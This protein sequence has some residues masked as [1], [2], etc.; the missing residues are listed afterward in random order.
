MRQDCGY[1]NDVVYEY[2]HANQ[3]VKNDCIYAHV[4]SKQST[5]PMNHVY[6]EHCILFSTTN[7]CDCACNELLTKKL[8]I[9]NQNESAERSL[10][11]K[12]DA[13]SVKNA[14]L[15]ITCKSPSKEGEDVFNCCVEKSICNNTDLTHVHG[16]YCLKKGNLNKQHFHHVD[17]DALCDNCISKSDI[18]SYKLYNAQ[19]NDGS[20]KEN[21][22]KCCDFD[23]PQGYYNVLNGDI[24]NVDKRRVLFGVRNHSNSHKIVMRVRS[25]L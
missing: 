13:I 10:E 17:E 8:S 6:N 12:Q 5:L 2:N 20:S 19:L 25:S 7:H 15:D 22:F 23:V 11:K 18:F 21:V 9:D 4:G 24:K 16:S 14:H 3:I 1:N